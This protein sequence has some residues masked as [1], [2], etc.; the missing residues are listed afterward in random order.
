MLTKDDLLVHSSIGLLAELV[1]FPEI[2][3]VL[4][5]NSAAISVLE[6]MRR[7]IS[8]STALLAQKILK[9]V[10]SIQPIIS[11]GHYYV[12][13][14]H[15]TTR[16]NSPCPT[17]SI[18]LMEAQTGKIL[19][20]N[21]YLYFLDSLNESYYPRSYSINH[22]PNDSAYYSMHESSEHNIYSI[23]SPIDDY[24][25][26]MAEGYQSMHITSTTGSG[27]IRL[28]ASSKAE[29]RLYFKFTTSHHTQPA[30]TNIFYSACSINYANF[31]Q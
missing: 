24:Y 3:A 12:G 28:S 21:S 31:F 13:T 10:G 25:N 14:P 17:M 23:M 26:R 20:I 8:G 9:C 11:S 29:F 4:S 1:N 30:F 7:N 5:S 15:R 2:C 19:I 22:Q 16:E 27:K 18:G 6:N